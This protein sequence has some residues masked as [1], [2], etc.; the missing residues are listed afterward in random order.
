MP[1]HI[2]TR[3]TRP[4]TRRFSL[5][6][7]LVL[8]ATLLLG[9]HGSALGKSSKQKAPASA[10]TS[11]TE[12]DIQRGIASFYSKGFEGRKTANG[13]IYRGETLTAAHRTLPF[14]TK[15]RVKNLRNGREVIVRINNR[16]PFI[17]KR[18]VD[19]SKRAAREVGMLKSGIVPV[20]LEVLE[21]PARY[22]A[23]R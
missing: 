10:A 16:G 23:G 15:V 1:F 6:I 13:E 4:Q 11:Q 20:E 22:R 12:T 17:K 18:I 8:T 9:F 5:A 3:I 2:M 21:L 7:T 14:G 19:L